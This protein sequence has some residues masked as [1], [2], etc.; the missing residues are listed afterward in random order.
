MAAGR[1][2]GHA[3]RA[4]AA[5]P[6]DGQSAANAWCEIQKTDG[7]VVKLHEARF[8]EGTPTVDGL[9]PALQIA[10]AYGSF[11]RV[12]TN[13]IRSANRDRL[14]KMIGPRRF[15]EGRG[16]P[17]RRAQAHLINLKTGTRK[18][19]SLIEMPCLM[20]STEWRSGT[21]YDNNLPS[22]FA[23]GRVL[24]EIKEA[25]G[26]FDEVWNMRVAMATDS[27]SGELRQLDISDL[28]EQNGRYHFEVVQALECLREALLEGNAEACL[29][30]LPKLATSDDSKSDLRVIWQWMTNADDQR[31]HSD[32]Y[33]E[34]ERSSSINELP[35]H[36][37]TDGMSDASMQ[38]ECAV[39]GYVP[40][41]PRS[42]VMSEASI[43]DPDDIDPEPV[44]PEDKPQHL[45]RRS[46]RPHRDF[47]PPIPVKFGITS[48]R[49]GGPESDEEGD[50]DAM[51]EYV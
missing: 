51:D 43:D 31:D 12:F 22:D 38:N 26:F 17:G 50:A 32:P 16:W 21:G 6:V 28:F 5:I 46:K 37:G 9:T 27:V 48:H 35:K 1:A 30:K 20:A 8:F 4:K 39:D 29:V 49:A 24:D 15:E 2:W 42:S 41:S 10:D 47:Y 13:M 3:K 44:S 33:M 19:Q 34:D 23:E 25:M 11:V 14:P 36:E 7:T 45:V 40:N 18:I